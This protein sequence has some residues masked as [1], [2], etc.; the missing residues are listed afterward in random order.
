[1]S[2]PFE[3][4]DTFNLINISPQTHSM[5]AS[6]WAQ[7]ERWTLKIADEHEHADTFVV[8]G[9]LWMPAKQSGPKLFEFQYSAIGTPPS[10]VSVPTHFF[11][12]IVAIDKKNKQLFK[13]ACFVVPNIEF[14]KSSQRRSLED[15]LVPWTSL[16]AV[17][18][19]H[20][21]PALT[22]D[23]NWKDR[24][25]KLTTEL[26]NPKQQPLLLTDGS[27]STGGIWKS[28]SPV[29]LAHFCA[30]GRCR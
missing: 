25:N 3:N 20:F 27:K 19:L 18:G 8:S 15:F 7:L 11:K 23:P 21:F 16:E 14:D 10:L 26:M 4:K 28:R 17:T 30:S 24:A 6:V 5:N 1:M 9:P 22:K 29:P 12:V 2:L 13:F